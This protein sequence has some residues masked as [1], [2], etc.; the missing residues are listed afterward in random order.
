MN[1]D[2]IIHKEALHQFDAEFT[3]MPRKHF[4]HSPH[5]HKE[6]EIAFILDGTFKTCYDGTEYTLTKGSVLL[7]GSNSIHYS[8]DFYAEGE[9]ILLIIDPQTLLGPAAQLSK[10]TPICPVW[11]NPEM[12]SI[13]WSSIQYALDNKANLHS[14]DL[15]LLLSSILSLIIRDMNMRDLSQNIKA[16]HRVLNYCRNHYTEPIS[17]KSVAKAL[18]FSESYV[19]H[20]FRNVLGR[21]FPQH[22]N[23]LRI[24][25]SATL[26]KTTNLSCTQIAM[27]SGFSTL[28]TFN[29]VFLQQYKMTPL[30]YRKQARLVEAKK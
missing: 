3:L 8:T 5:Y 12:D 28:R 20:L 18:Y 23:A 9:W 16:E 6:L 4:K 17:I 24:A 15:V 19:S 1:S 26:L 7:C 11:N 2:N 21:S 13:I 22:I 27:E 30:Q 25:H 10:K 29:H 14:E